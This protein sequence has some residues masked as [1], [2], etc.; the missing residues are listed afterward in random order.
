M[1]GVSLPTKASYKVSYQ[2]DQAEILP[3]VLEESFKLFEDLLNNRIL[4]TEKCGKCFKNQ[5]ANF[6]SGKHAFQNSNHLYLKRQKV[7]YC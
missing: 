7:Y 1:G 4:K 6:V 3:K 5:N 2:K